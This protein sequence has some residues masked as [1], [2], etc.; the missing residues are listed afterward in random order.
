M[1]SIN[2][3]LKLKL[4][5]DFKLIAGEKGIKNKM[6][7]VV[8]LEYESIK[9]TYEV[10]SE[11]DFVLSSLFFAKDDTSLIEDAMIKLMRRKVSG[12]AIK[13]VFFNDIPQSVKDLAEKLNIPIFTFS[14]AYMEDL[15]ISANEL[16]KS[17]LLYLKFEE[18]I[19][20]LLNTKTPREKVIDT[21]NNI[22]P[23]LHKY[24]ITAYFTPKNPSKSDRLTSYFQRL[25]YNRYKTANSSNYSYVKYR[26]GMMIIYSFDNYPKSPKDTIFSLLKAIDLNIDDFSIGISD[27][28]YEK[29]KFNLSMKEA[30]NS[31]RVC[32]LE[33]KPCVCYS[34]IGIYE[35]I[36]PLLDNENIIANCNKKIK[37]LTDYDNKHT[38]DLLNTLVVFI[39][40]AG[41]I[42]ATAKELFQHPNTIRYR[43]NKICNLLS[44]DENNAY[45]YLFTLVKLHLICI[46]TL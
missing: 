16:L 4:F 9:N 36:L 24:I 13:T 18:Q 40:C 10:F 25:L 17:K 21:I 29:D 37:I 31:N 15:I 20:K 6:T 39:N 43:I 42:S 19:T 2:E 22:N 14:N 3:L 34:D 28:C 8:I 12:I 7:N 23:E 33:K 26:Q 46:N 11:G 27:T 44:I 30:I 45:N 38:S 1:I 32:Q 41:E 35:F 5:D